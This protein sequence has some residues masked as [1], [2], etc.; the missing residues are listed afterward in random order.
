MTEVRIRAF[1]AA[2]GQAQP[3]CSGWVA[4][5]V[6]AEKRQLYEELSPGTVSPV[7]H[8]RRP[9]V[10]EREFPDDGQSEPAASACLG[11]IVV[12]PHEPVPDAFGVGLG[13]TGAVI[14]DRY[15]RPVIGR[16]ERQFHP[17]VRVPQGVIQQVSD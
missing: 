5:S 7:A 4:G 8:R 11:T 9:A 14:G 6:L 2:T 16:R 10:G 13:Y 15:A 17:A 12:E 3:R 1:M